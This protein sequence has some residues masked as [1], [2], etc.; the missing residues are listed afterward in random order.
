MAFSGRLFVRFLLICMTFYGTSTVSADQTFTNVY[1][2]THIHVLFEESNEDTTVESHLNDFLTSS[3]ITKGIVLSPSYIIDER[4][5][6]FQ[7]QDHLREIHNQKTADLVAKYP[8]KLIGLCGLN[9]IWK[10]GAEITE[11]CLANPQ[12]VGIKIRVAG[13]EAVDRL[14]DKSTF[15]L[16]TK[17]IS[18]NRN[19][20]RT[21]LIHMPDDYSW[22]NSTRSIRTEEELKRE[23]KKNI[24]EI[25][26]LVK[27]GKMF[28]EI[29]FIIAH[30]LNSYELINELTK[31]LKANNLKNFWID[32]S[33]SLTNLIPDPMSG[34]SRMSTLEKFAEA[35]R[36]FGIR[37][38]LFGSDQIT[39]LHS[40]YRSKHDQG[41]QFVKQYESITENPFLDLGEKY[42]ILKYNGEKF[43]NL[44]CDTCRPESLDIKNTL[45]NAR[46]HRKFESHILRGDI[47]QQNCGTL[48]QCSCTQNQP[49][50]EG[51]VTPFGTTLYDEHLINN[52]EKDINDYFLSWLENPQRG[53]NKVDFVISELMKKHQVNQKLDRWETILEFVKEDLIQIFSA[54]A[55]RQYRNAIKRKVSLIT[56]E[57]DFHSTPELLFHTGANS[58]VPIYVG[59]L[60]AMSVTSFSAIY[61]I[62]AHE[63]A[64]EFTKNADNIFPAVKHCI[65]SNFSSF[66]F[67]EGINA[68]LEEIWADTYARESLAIRMNKLN[69][70]HQ[71]QANGL[72]NTMRLF[73]GYQGSTGGHPSGQWRSNALL[74]NPTLYDIMKKAQYSLEQ[75][76]L[77]SCTLK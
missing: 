1:L 11:K 61:F 48:Y 60:M 41:S 4:Y 24:A 71:K 57:R 55:D 39:G 18:H 76:Q 9:Y 17:S 74:D 10:D 36:R 45:E 25:K 40:I 19:K 70:T 77:N 49:I 43:F 62:L 23:F 68:D 22:L 47:S 50:D 35:W 8:G 53:E 51:T 59:G 16:I 31:Q 3:Q 52:I 6:P 69:W 15:D 2:D 73:C 46:S 20:V 32:V 66:S 26:K 56:I 65:N 67:L 75:P 38:I 33:T 42:S 13:E 63:L 12:M 21:V 14:T 54:K 7:G 34:I 27:I 28:P 30:S 64:H 5:E 58:G 37:K 72:R 29:Q 44:I